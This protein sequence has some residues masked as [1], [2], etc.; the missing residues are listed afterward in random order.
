MA[1]WRATLLGLAISLGCVLPA[2]AAPYNTVRAQDF[3]GSDWMQGPFHRVAVTAHNNG[4]VNRYTVETRHGIHMINGTD[5]T[6]AFI[7]EINAAED[8]KHKSTVGMAGTALKNRVVN[9]VKTP[10]RVVKAVGDRIDTVNS[11]EDAVLLA[12]RITIDLGGKLIN[13]AGEM[14]YTGNRLLK[15]DGDGTK[16]QGLGNCLSK[17]GEDVLSGMN[18]VAGKHNSARKLHARYGTDSETR[19]PIL[20]REVDRLAYA[21]AY[22]K[23]SAKLFAPN[24]GLSD[25]DTYRMGVRFYN[26]SEL[27]AGYK[28]A[29]RARNQ[30]TERLEARGIHPGLLK[31]FQKNENYTKKE[32]VALIDSLERF[33]P[34]ANI[35]PFIEDAAKANTVYEAKSFVDRYHYLSQ[36][37]TRRGIHNFTG[38]SMP[39]AVTRGGHHILT[40]KADYLNWTAQTGN[41]VADLARL[42]KSEIHIL[43]HASPDFKRRAQSH[44]V[45]IVEVHNNPQ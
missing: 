41:A 20:K 25:F 27:V 33:G 30:Q 38:T 3:L 36:L 16:C 28:D 11:V 24:T 44:G 5:Q 32:R 40:L 15:S 43:G 6:R 29:Y 39:I 13:G 37:Q 1:I 34:I 21:E 23:T 31:A 12:P 14:I 18:S 7:R 2:I 10:V 45:K 42:R 19:N 26:N 35:G 22:T 17:A 9:L 4:Q 8:L